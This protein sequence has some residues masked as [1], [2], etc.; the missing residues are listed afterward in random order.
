MRIRSPTFR[1]SIRRGP[2]GVSISVPRVK[3]MT[4]RSSVTNT[5]W[6]S[7]SWGTMV[8]VPDDGKPAGSLV[9]TRFPLDSVSIG[10]VP[11]G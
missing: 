10:V 5:G 6:P 8:K 1:S 4:T 9:K 7:T 11:S 3:Q 2:S